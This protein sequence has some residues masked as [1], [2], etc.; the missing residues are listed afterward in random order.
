MLINSL[1]GGVMI[2]GGLY[3][4]LWGRSKEDNQVLLKTELLSEK[5]LSEKG[6]D[7]EGG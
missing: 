5:L 7:V 3:F 6:Q 2:I 4:V 1:L